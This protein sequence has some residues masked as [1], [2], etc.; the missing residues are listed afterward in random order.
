MP[1]YNRRDYLRLAIASVLAQSH[2]HIEIIV[3]DNASPQDPSDMVAAFA[4]PRLRL[5]R[6]PST[7]GQTANFLA[8]IGHAS[9]KYVAIMGDDDLWQP[10]FVATLVAPM[11]ADGGIVVAFCD[12]GIIDAQGRTDAAQTERVTRRFG[13]HA[14]RDGVHEAFDD[15]A[16]VYRAICI[17]SGA[18]IRAGAIDWSQVPTDLPASSDIYIAYLLAATGRRCWYTSR[19]LM[20]YRYHPAQAMRGAGARSGYAAW[21]LEM[22]RTFLLDRRLRRRGYYRM[23]CARWA[24]IIAADRLAKRD[25]RTLAHWSFLRMLDPRVLVYH[26]FYLVRFQAMGMRRLM[27]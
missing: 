17:V 27:P 18:I 21:T 15:V 20:Q 11:E 26:L 13:R 10:D 25:W 23:V 22:W 3:Q 7:I 4:D 2:R 5:Y 1:T 19:R 6:N 14:I 12:H 9:G 8:G 24:L 16:L